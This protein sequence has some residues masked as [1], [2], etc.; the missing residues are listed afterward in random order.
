MRRALH[1]GMLATVLLYAGAT[2]AA[3][4]RSMVEAVVSRAVLERGA[5]LAC[6]R[7]DKDRETTEALERGWKADIDD[8]S[9]L[10]RELGYAAD[11]VDTFAG[12]FNIETATPRFTDDAAAQ[13]FCAMLGD[14][15]R[16][17][18]AFFFLAPHL[19][20]KRLSQK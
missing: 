20:I 5:M 19:E 14:W 18:F 9:K 10:L 17:Y 4:Y 8:T 1:A 16:H 13:K 11:Y 7:K 2:H 3:E 15:R 6:A 12:R